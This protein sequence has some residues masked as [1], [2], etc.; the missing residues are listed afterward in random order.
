MSP[1]P[2]DVGSLKTGL[3]IREA[4]SVD[5]GA[6]ADLHASCFERFWSAAD[7]AAM[8]DI[9]GTVVLHASTGVQTAGFLVARTASDE[10]EILSIAV[11]RDWRRRGLARD[12]VAE[13]DVRLSR[14]RIRHL[15]LEVDAANTAAIALYGSCGFVNVGVRRDYYRRNDGTRSD[16]LILRR[17]IADGD[18]ID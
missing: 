5:C 11:S 8:M 14:E 6:I 16:A 9:P 1:S 17:N 10:A 12:L 18:S 4:G 2:S 7:I 13:L 3:D 15:L